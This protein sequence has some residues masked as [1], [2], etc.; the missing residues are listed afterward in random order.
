MTR[1]SDVLITNA[2]IVLPHAILENGWLLIQNGQIAA[3][4]TAGEALPELSSEVYRVDGKGGYV[5]PG[6]IDI[7]V[8]GGAGVDFM[9][10][11]DEELKAVTRFHMENGTTAMLATTVTASNEAL[12]QVISRVASY[13]SKPMPYAQLL[14][15]HLEGPFVNPKWK[16]AQ[17]DV[18]MV[19]PQP[20]WLN[21]WVQKYPDTIKLQTLA[22]EL[23]GAADYIRLLKQYGIVAACG[24]TDATFEEIEHA[25]EH[26]LSHAVHTFNAMRALHHRE[27]GT[28]GAVLLNDSISGE[29][30]ADGEHV[31]PAA[32]KLLLK[33]KGVEHVVLVT[34]AISAAGMPDGDYTLG[35][36]PVIVEQGTAR[37]KE[38]G[39]LAGSTLTMI[40][41]FKYLVNAVGASITEASRISSLN[42]ARTLGISNEYGSIEVGKRADVL[43]LDEN[44]NVSSV[45]IGG[46]ATIS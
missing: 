6:F 30:I 25:V 2:R 37:L 18:F 8:H 35:S 19:K 4:G 44:F 13:K 16:G 26:G 9:T 39:S 36:L 24:H 27:P 45:F 10:A 20:Q 46:V 15:V 29:I 28:V 7:H 11:D 17:D 12:T 31:N 1:L 43:L 23:E 40:K 33:A 38:G 14:G 5:L 34:D 22:P 41:G 42:P 32:I 21:D 3:T